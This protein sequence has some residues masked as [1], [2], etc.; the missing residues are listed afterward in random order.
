MYDAFEAN[1]ARSMFA[2][3]GEKT[4]IDKVLAK[5]DV[6]QI[7]ALIK[8]PKLTR[9]DLLELQYLL[10]GTEAKLVNYSEYDR[11]IILKFFVWIREFIKIAELLFDY[12]EEL[13]LKSNI[14][15]KC[16]L[17]IKTLRETEKK[18]ECK[19]PIPTMTLTKRAQKL[20]DNNSILIQHNAKF[21]I[22]LYLNIARTSMSVGAGGFLELIRN[23]YE[24]YYPNMQQQQQPQGFFSMFTGKKGG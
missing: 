10:T 18:C 4:F 21:L 2:Q 24:L 6:N 15:R 13:A 19:P 20:F 14:C 1:L 7:K 5:D 3:Q 9:E 16:T 22:D 17:I 8:K 23:K 11:Y 12:E